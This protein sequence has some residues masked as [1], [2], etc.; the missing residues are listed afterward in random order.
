MCLA[1]KVY[2][3]FTYAQN[4]LHAKLIWARPGIVVGI[5]DLGS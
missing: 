2:R 5:E 4:L 1:M 3:T